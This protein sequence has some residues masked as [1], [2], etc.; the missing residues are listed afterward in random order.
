MA[1]ILQ[2][3][4]QGSWRSNASV[5]SKPWRR[6]SRR[7]HNIPRKDSRRRRRRSEGERLARFFLLSFVWYVCFFVLCFGTCV[8]FVLFF[9]SSFKSSAVL[10]SIGLASR[11]AM[12]NRP[13]PREE[14]LIFS[15][16]ITAVDIPTLSFLL[17]YPVLS[18]PVL[19][20]PVYAS[21]AV[22]SFFRWPRE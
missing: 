15:G 20:C 5:L 17:S 12:C 6:P 8:F 7:T 1:L 9:M 11:L 4:G 22:R 18:F 21:T 19:S 16:L 2:H 10:N 14:W 13:S 3:G